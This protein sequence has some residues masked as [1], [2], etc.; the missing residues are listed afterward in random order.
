MKKV[1]ILLVGVL[2]V[3]GC[4]KDDMLPIIE[5]QIKPELQI[6]DKFGIKLQTSFVTSEVLMN[7]KL[8]NSG[9]ATIKITDISNRVVSKEQVNVSVGDNLLK[10]YTSALPPS[11]YRIAL[12]DSNNNMLGI[13]DFNKIN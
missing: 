8:E 10:V 5:Q 12:Y 9:T 13:T 2:F 6:A 11:A 3:A 1:L 7:V 4:T